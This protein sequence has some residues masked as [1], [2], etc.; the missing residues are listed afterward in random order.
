MPSHRWLSILVFTVVSF[1][2]SVDQKDCV[3]TQEYRSYS[4]MIVNGNHQP[5]DSLVT[6]VTDKDSQTVYRTDSSSLLDP[7]HTPGRYIVLTDGEIKYFSSGPGMVIFHASNQKYNVVET[8]TF[9]VDDCRC[10][11]QKVSGPDSTIV[12]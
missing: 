10:H 12:Q 4:I 6:W 8:F 5:V 11:L 3:C 7:Y 2:C 9:S 1:S